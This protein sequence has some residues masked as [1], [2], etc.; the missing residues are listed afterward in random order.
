[1]STIILP[2]NRNCIFTIS[3]LSREKDQANPVNPV[4]KYFGLM[5]R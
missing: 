5:I 3:S 2:L 1:M 4:K